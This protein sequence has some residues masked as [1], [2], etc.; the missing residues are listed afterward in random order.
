MLSSSDD[1][2][3]ISQIF[4]RAEHNGDSSKFVLTPGKISFNSPSNNRPTAQTTAHTTVATQPAAELCSP[5][6]DPD[7]DTIIPLNTQQFNYEAN[8]RASA[9]EMVL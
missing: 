4:S 7:R 1:S 8:V 2:V 3:S 6:R 5:D 9:C